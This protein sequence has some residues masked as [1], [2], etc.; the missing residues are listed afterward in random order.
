MA[1]DGVSVA[2]GA[3]AFL[4]VD[5]M[6]AFDGVAKPEVAL[7]HN[8]SFYCGQPVFLTLFASDKCFLAR[9][10]LLAVSSSG[11]PYG[12]LLPASQLRFSRVCVCS[13]VGFVWRDGLYVLGCV[14]VADLVRG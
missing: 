1:V 6:A 9:C 5:V 14:C 11:A 13:I 2:E 10:G 7:R 8:L 3:R 4:A 12:F